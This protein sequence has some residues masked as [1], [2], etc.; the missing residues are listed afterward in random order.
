MA[1]S[2]NK[3]SEFYTRLNLYYQQD[4]HFSD[5][6]INSTN[7]TNYGL[8]NEPLKNRSSEV[9]K[10][11]EDGITIAKQLKNDNRDIFIT[12]YNDIIAS[13]FGFLFD[14]KV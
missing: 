1:L 10:A 2:I 4:N 14:V 9:D 13:N 11:S 8:N 12:K 6:T 7:K 3:I 5:R